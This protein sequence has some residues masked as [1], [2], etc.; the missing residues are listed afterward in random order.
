MLTQEID[1]TVLVCKRLLLKQR[2]LLD[3]VQ[4]ILAEVWQQCE[5]HRLLLVCRPCL[6]AKLFKLSGLAALW[7]A[8]TVRLQHMHDNDQ[9]EVAKVSPR[10]VSTTDIDTLA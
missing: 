8:S 2:S 1:C 10:S 5:G 3:T 7:S 9:H 6:Q 4:I